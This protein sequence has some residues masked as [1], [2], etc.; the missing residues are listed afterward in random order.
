MSRVNSLMSV[1]YTLFYNGNKLY[2]L[3]LWTCTHCWKNESRRVRTTVVMMMAILQGNLRIILQT[4]VLKCT[5]VVSFKYT[6]HWILTHSYT[7]KCNLKICWKNKWLLL[8]IMTQAFQ[9]EVNIPMEWQEIL[10]LK[11]YYEKR[12]LQTWMK[13]MHFERQCQ[14]TYPLILLWPFP[15]QTKRILTIVLSENNNWSKQYP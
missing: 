6:Q 15:R 11:F 9:N 13:C 2:D 3:Y 4:W 12:K 8:S 1:S 5:T 14:C 7:L 10:W